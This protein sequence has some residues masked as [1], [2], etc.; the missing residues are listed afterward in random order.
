MA[1][2]KQLNYFVNGEW[3]TSKTEKYMDVYNPS[4][5]EVIARTPCCTQEEVEEAIASA[6]AAFPAWSNTPVMK[7]VQV[8][9]KFRELLVEHMDEL[10]TLCALEHGKVLSEA[11]GDI[12]KVKEPVELALSAPSL[13]MGDSMR[14]TSSGYDTTLYYEPVGVFGSDSVEDIDSV[15]K[16]VGLRIVQLHRRASAEDVAALRALGYEVWTLAG[17][18][19]GDGVLFDSTHGDGEKAFR[20]VTGRSILAGGIAAENLPAAL[21]L[22]PDVVDVSGSLESSPGVKD[23]RRIEDFFAK[24]NSLAH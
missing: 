2:I 21:A 13:T 20:K 3:K 16:S 12:L 22:G 9:Y 11:K 7:R 1:E 4:T 8:L 6:K 18:A 23:P 14:D 5:G 19:E 10:A 15:A 24:F 17:G